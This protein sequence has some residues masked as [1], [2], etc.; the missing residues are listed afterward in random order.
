MTTICLKIHIDL[1]K[2]RISRLNLKN[3]L[4]IILFL[5]KYDVS[6]DCVIFTDNN[7]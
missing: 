5:M 1:K 2:A 4:M 3:I 7:K 6:W